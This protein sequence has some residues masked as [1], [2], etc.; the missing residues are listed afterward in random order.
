MKPFVPALLALSASAVLIPAPTPA[1]LGTPQVTIAYDKDVYLPGEEAK[2]TIT[3]APGTLV[4]LGFDFDDGPTTLPGF[5]TFDLGFSNTFKFA[6]MPPIPASGSATYTWQCSNP[7]ENP[8]SLNN[9]YTQGI[10]LDPVTM[11]F[12]MTNSDVLDVE[13]L[14]GFCDTTGCT[15][16]YWKNHH[17][18]WGPTG[19]NPSDSWNDT[20]GVM[21]YDPDVTLA[22]ALDPP[23]ELQTFGAHSVA[24]LLNSLHPG[25]S[26]GLS[27]DEVLTLVQD[28]VNSGNWQ[29]MLDVKDILANLNEAGCPF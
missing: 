15:P 18:T 28:A 1:A 6:L 12:G 25:E 20:F 4:W 2:L 5:G 9:L 14:F 24:A 16:G 10:T 7:C 26:Y 8:I 23:T 27:S 13:D 19:L 17:Q 3:G 29:E 21:G 22:Q 11:E